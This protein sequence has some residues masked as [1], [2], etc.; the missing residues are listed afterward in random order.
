MFIF[1][2]FNFSLHLLNKTKNDMTAIEFN[3]HLAQQR[4]PLKNF[5][6]KLTMNGEDANDLVQDTFLKAIT[7]KD[8][9]KDATNIK[10]WLYTI[11][12]NTFINNY[13]R[14]T[15]K[16]TILKD[17]EEVQKAP[18]TAKVSTNNADSNLN[19][20]QIQSALE[21]LGDEYKVPFIKHFNGHKYQEI[22]EELDLPI[23]TI[24]SRIFIARKKLMLELRDF[25]NS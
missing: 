13:R 20:K 11:M 22:S 3:T 4:T 9:F 6:L 23:G 8:K 10:A 18:I 25:Y 15:K 12:K 19:V 14:A 7:Y 16:R 21:R 5:A 17:A 2:L 1:I 24:K